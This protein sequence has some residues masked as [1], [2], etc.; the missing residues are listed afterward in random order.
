MKALFGML[1]LIVC[2]NANASDNVFDDYQQKYVEFNNLMVDAAEGNKSPPNLKNAS[3]S[4]AI[5]ALTNDDW[6]NKFASAPTDSLL[7]V[8]MSC[9]YANEIYKHYLM[10]TKPTE[11]F[12]ASVMKSNMVEFQNE[13]VQ[14]NRFNLRCYS[15]L[16]TRLE[17]F[18]L[19]LSEEERTPTRVNGLLQVKLGIVQVYMSNILLIDSD[20]FTLKNKK[21]LLDTLLQITPDYVK[22][23]SLSDRKIIIDLINQHSSSFDKSFKPQ[24]NELLKLLKTKECNVL[25]A[26]S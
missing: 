25:C 3:Q 17:Q 19:N 20:E 24:L 6:L 21:V 10:F 12:S 1:C 15:D 9:G 11:E 13:M 18:Y 2:I 7:D 14:F 16:M 26:V 5:L 8:L 23:M 4:A 22:I